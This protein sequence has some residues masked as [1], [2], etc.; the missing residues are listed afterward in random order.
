MKLH[1]RRQAARHLARDRR[2]GVE[3]AGRRAGRRHGAGTT[4]DHGRGGR[5]K[6]P[7]TVH[8][9]FHA[10]RARRTLYGNR[11]PGRQGREG[12]GWAGAVKPNRFFTLTRR[13]QD[14]ACFAVV[15]AALAVSQWIDT[16]TQTVTVGQSVPNNI[17]AILAKIHQPLRD[18]SGPSQGEFRDI[19]VQRVDSLC[20]LSQRAS[21]R[22]P[23]D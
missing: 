1:R 20:A 10:D 3:Q 4:A 5:H 6:G 17:R 8:Y 12:H 9:Q 15:F 2:V 11:H 13:H 19:M 16:G 23:C 18:Q 22:A 7:D 21:V 14:R